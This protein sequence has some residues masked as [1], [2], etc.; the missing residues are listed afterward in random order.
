MK[1]TSTRY[2]FSL[3]LAVLVQGC[4]GTDI[5]D[6]FVEPRI[7]ATNQVEA[8]LVGDSYLYQASFFDNTGVERP[9][10]FQWSSSDQ[11]VLLINGEG[12]AMAVAPGVTTITYSAN[13]LS[14]NFTVTVFDPQQV[15]EDSLRMQQEQTQSGD[16]TA[17]LVTV[18]SYLLEGTAVLTVDDGLILELLDDF[19]TTDALPGLY[20]YLTNNTRSV[21]NAVEI[22]EVT[23]ATGAQSYVVPAGVELQD[24][25]Y[26]L[27]YCKPFRVPVGEGKFEP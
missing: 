16:R 1:V 7:S 27:F 26:V 20:L 12:L 13:D 6:D 10:S 24:F 8:L 9:A 21:S 15:D 2:L 3:L 23:M 19:R 22:G 11:Q 5:V 18:S 14:E 4:I 25:S 17:E